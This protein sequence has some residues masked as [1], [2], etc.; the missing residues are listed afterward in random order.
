MKSSPP[1]HLLMRIKFATWSM[2][3]S[4]SAADRYRSPCIFQIEGDGWQKATAGIEAEFIM[5]YNPAGKR[6]FKAVKINARYMSW[7]L[8]INELQRFPSAKVE[9][10]R[11]VL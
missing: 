4:R 9:D 3:T 2:T 7:T 8:R 5:L 6:I 11:R 10:S 1:Y